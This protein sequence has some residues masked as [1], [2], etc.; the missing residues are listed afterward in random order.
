[1]PPK[2]EEQ[3]AGEAKTDFLKQLKASLLTQDRAYLQAYGRVH[4]RRLT[5][6]EIDLKSALGD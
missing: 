3:P 4:G 5:R 6:V 2:K 1:M